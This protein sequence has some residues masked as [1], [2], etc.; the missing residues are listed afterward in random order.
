MVATILPKITADVPSSFKAP[1][2][3]WY[4]LDH[5]KLADPEF[6]GPAK[7][8]LILGADTSDKIMHHGR[9]TCKPGSPTALKTIFGWVL[10]G[11]VP[12]RV[13]SKEAGTCYVATASND[14][15]LRRFW[16]IEECKFKELV[17]SVKEKIDMNHFDATHV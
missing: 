7:V 1:S 14:D 16:E 12:R 13:I 8:D 9:R 3:E 17:L 6:A 15:E 10:M 2:K 4:H 11:P 5:I